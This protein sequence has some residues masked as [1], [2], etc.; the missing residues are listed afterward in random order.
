M[1]KLSVCIPSRNRQKYCIETIRSIAKSDVQDFEVIVGDNSDDP[2]PLAAFFETFD[3][4]RF[5]LVPP[6]ER[7]LSMAENWNRLIEYTS[8][9]WVTVIGDDD[10]IDPD[11]P[12]FISGLQ[13]TVPDV[14]ALSWMSMNYIWPDIRPENASIAVPSDCGIYVQS[15]REMMGRMFYWQGATDR[16][17]CSYGIYHGAIKREL[18]ET[19]KNTFGGK[20]F[21]HQIVD[22]ECIC[23]TILVAKKMVLCQRPLSVMGACAASNSA[24]VID[25]K[26]ME[27]RNK[28]F[29]NEVKN[30]E[31]GLYYPNGF[32]FH[33]EHGLTA[34]IASTIL[35]VVQE[36]GL[37]VVGWE[38]NFVLAS[39]NYCETAGTIEEYNARRKLYARTLRKWKGGRYLKYFNPKF[40]KFGGKSVAF[41]GVH[42]GKLYVNSDIN[43]AKTP[44]EAFDA[45]QCIMPSIEFVLNQLEPLKRAA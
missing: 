39:Q 42:Q 7:A 23:K 21:I 30:S 12:A 18:L 19:I 10:Y 33:D 16:P 29:V 17:L 25:S 31:H 40:A 8:G 22:Y 26:L 27:A 13:K 1:V 32:P 14:D 43:G 44:K 24:A 45:V 41:Q 38:K 20:Y 11:V 2:E 6:G 34:A 37:E 36:Y 9:E 5:K 28:T 15:Q 35:W 3:D 4:K